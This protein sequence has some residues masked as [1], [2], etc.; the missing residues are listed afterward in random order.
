MKNKYSKE[1]RAW[2]AQTRI[3]YNIFKSM[4][5]KDLEYLRDLGGLDPN[6]YKSKSLIA[7]GL[8]VKLGGFLPVEFDTWK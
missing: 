3:T 2:I 6:H 1:V 7:K 4:P 5:L 8:M